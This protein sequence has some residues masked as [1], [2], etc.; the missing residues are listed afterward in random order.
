MF[1]YY[2]FLDIT[3]K[4]EHHFPQFSAFAKNYTTNA[5]DDAIEIVSTIEDAEEWKNSHPN[6][7]GIDFPLSYLETL[8]IQSKIAN[9]IAK[10]NGFVFHGSTIY[11]DSPENAYIF[12]APSGTGKSTHSRLLK[13]MFGDRIN[14]INDDKPFIKLNGSEYNVY[15][16][17]WDGKERRS[18]NLKGVLRGIF[19]IQ[20]S[21][22]CDVEQIPGKEAIM[23]LIK[24][25]H[26]PSGI[27]NTLNGTE[28]IVNLCKNIPIY[29]LKVDM[30]ENA[31][32]TSYKIMS[33]ITEEK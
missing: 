14:Y 22:E 23:H 16:S 8:V 9:V 3:F 5:T 29:I 28:F 2:K 11:L 20:R 10:N 27:E 4:I 24:Q 12:T 32:K 33:K 31:P 30:S 17:P 15:G 7:E 25:I 1:E 21:L 13:S 19:V 6:E 26:I 18:N